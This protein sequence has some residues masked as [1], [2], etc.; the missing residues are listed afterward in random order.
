MSGASLAA[1]SVGSST[2]QRL[3]AATLT[4]AEP[5]SEVVAVAE[6]TGGRLLV[7]DRRERTFYVV[8][9]DGK[10]AAPLGRNGSGPNEYTGAF[11]IVRLPGDTLA[12]YGG[13]Q[14]FLRVSPDGSFL[15]ALTVPVAVMQAGGL[16][17]PRGADARGALYWTG[18]VVGTI[19]GGFKRNLFQNIRRWMPPAETIDTVA[20]VA[21]HAP[22]MHVHRFFPYAESDAW[23][24][25]P[26]GRIAVLSAAAYRLRWYE[27]GRVVAEGP[28]IPYTPVPITSDDRDAFRKLRLEQPAG[29]GR[30]VAT[31]GEAPRPSAEAI[32]RNREAY[33]DEIF[34]SHKPPFV[35]N[36]MLRAPTGQLWVIRSM[37]HG[38]L[39]AR[40]DILG[41]DGRRR[42]ELDLPDGRRLVGLERNGVWLARVDDDGLQWLERYPMPRVEP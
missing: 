28:A 33:P 25:A 2:P 4:V 13:S 39:R 35:E 34:P 40:I 12:L 11:G 23:A 30:L 10:T 20:P 1:Q 24:V 6:L 14:R 9:R 26:D 7:A 18:D 37:P 3:G 16:A 21:D 19:A 31:P 38:S 42:A 32:R 29:M 17:A 22:A 36:G 15:D 41:A 8:S 5:F 27:A